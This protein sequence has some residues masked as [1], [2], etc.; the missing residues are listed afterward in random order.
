MVRRPRRDSDNNHVSLESGVMP[1]YRVTIETTRTVMQVYDIVAKSKKDAIAAIRK[2]EVEPVD[3]DLA[4][5][6]SNYDDATI[7]TI[8]S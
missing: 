2:G 7:D 1:K 5:S 8:N 6:S 4:E 3:E